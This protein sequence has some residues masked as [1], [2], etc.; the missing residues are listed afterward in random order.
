MKYGV[1]VF[2]LA[3]GLFSFRNIFSQTLQND[4]LASAGD[5]FTMNNAEVTWTL[6]ESVIES[7]RAGNIFISEGFHQPLYKFFEISE[8][9]SPAFQAIIYPNPATAFI[10]IDLAGSG[11]QEDF[12]LILSTIIGKVLINQSINSKITERLDLSGYSEGI[13]L[14]KIIRLRDGSQRV[15]KIIRTG[16]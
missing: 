8:N 1:L 16:Y 12:R 15:F 9:G 10:Q 5:S 6:G 2:I 13:L 11:D 4:V 3:L 14:M 7:Y